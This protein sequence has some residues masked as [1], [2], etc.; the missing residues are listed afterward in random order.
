MALLQSY[1]WSGG[2]D[3]TTSTSPQ[4]AFNVP[5]KDFSINSDGKTIRHDE[6]DRGFLFAILALRDLMT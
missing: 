6:Y 3:F 5:T 2:H 1:S 4:L